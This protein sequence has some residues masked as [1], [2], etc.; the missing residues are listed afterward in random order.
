MAKVTLKIYGN[1][2]TIAGD[3]SEE[4][5]RKIASKVDQMMRDLGRQG[6]DTTATGLAVLAAVNMSEDCLDLEKHV[7]KLT[8]DKEKIEADADYYMKMWEQSKKHSQQNKEDVG[9]IKDKLKD[10]RERIKELSA[11]CA[12]YENNFFDIQM[13]NIR[14]KNELEKMKNK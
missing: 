7:E 14:L 3:R 5:I 8:Q 9:E 10:S 12:E 2:Y 6:A 4:E 11:K 13:E 1:E